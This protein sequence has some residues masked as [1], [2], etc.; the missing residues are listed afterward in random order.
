MHGNVREWNALQTVVMRGNMTQ[1]FPPSAH[2]YTQTPYPAVNTRRMLPRLLLLLLWY[3]PASR[4]TGALRR[5]NDVAVKRMWRQSGWWSHE[6][7]M[8]GGADETNQS[9]VR[10]TARLFLISACGHR[11]AAESKIEHD[12][13]INATRRFRDVTRRRSRRRRRLTA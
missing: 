4:V 1:P 2:G 11:A 10:T 5:T 7:A 12:T 8:S 13:A 3:R 9:A 6:Y